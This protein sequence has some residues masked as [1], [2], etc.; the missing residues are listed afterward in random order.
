MEQRTSEELSSQ[1]DSPIASASD[2][3][4]THNVTMSDVK[5]TLTV[6]HQMTWMG[7]MT[8]QHLIALEKMIFRATMKNCVHHVILIVV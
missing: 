7:R 6:N 5:I 4:S 3:T 2:A 1:I 8:R